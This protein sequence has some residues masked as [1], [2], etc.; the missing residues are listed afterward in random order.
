MRVRLVKLNGA[1][2][3]YNSESEE[4]INKLSENEVYYYDVKKERNPQFHAKLFVLFTIGYQNVETKL[5]F[6]AWRKIKTMEAGYF[7]S[8]TTEK[9][10]YFEAKSLSFEKMSQE[11]F[12]DLY[13]KV[14]QVIANEIGTTNEELEIQLLTEF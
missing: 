11:E 6:D 12:D 9:G 3:A 2:W 10:T 8:W 5:P 13:S 1:L 4:V 7:D 14:L